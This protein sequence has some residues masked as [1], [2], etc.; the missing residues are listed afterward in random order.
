M[1][2]TIDLE[3]LTP[4]LVRELRPLI[5][6]NH[7]ASGAKEDLDPP[8]SRLSELDARHAMALLVA[9]VDGFAVGYLAQVMNHSHLNNALAASVVAVYVD[10]GHRSLA[11]RLLH[12]AEQVAKDGG[13][14]SFSV[15]VPGGKVAEWLT[16]MGYERTEVVMRKKLAG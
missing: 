6:A 15:A 3:S 13:A 10:P 9:R 5:V 14:A 4:D 1:T 12:R 8:W 11:A 2:T 7:A 16:L